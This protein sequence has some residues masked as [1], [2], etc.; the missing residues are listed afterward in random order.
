MPRKHRIWYPGAVYHIMCRG[1]HRHDIFR[2]EEDRQFYLT[3][4]RRVQ[5]Q[6]PFYLYSYCLMTNHV[7]LQMETLDIPINQ[8]MQRI[9]M[10]Y[11]IYFN[12]TIL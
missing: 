10:L 12:Q 11:S 8:I 7:H 5:K 4:L 9:N 3:T 6:N 1:N 2:D